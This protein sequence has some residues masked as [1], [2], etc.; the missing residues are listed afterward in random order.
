MRAGR[1][2]ANARRRELGGSTYRGGAPKASIE[3]E[4]VSSQVFALGQ[5]QPSALAYPPARK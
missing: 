3:V 2:L 4:T 1:V 5:K